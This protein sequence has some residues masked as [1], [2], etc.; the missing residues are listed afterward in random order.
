MYHLQMLT[1]DEPFFEGEIESLIIPGEIGYLGIL[2]DH[3]PLISHLVQGT[4]T[5]TEN[6]KSKRLYK[7]SEGFFKVKNNQA[8]LLVETIEELPSQELEDFR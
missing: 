6:E 1:P 5:V 7:I 3:A 2:K 4:V 8:V